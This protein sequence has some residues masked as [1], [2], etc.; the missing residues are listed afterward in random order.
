[1]ICCP[2]GLLTELIHVIL[3]RFQLLENRICMKLLLSNAAERL[4]H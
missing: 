2:D 3:A 4:R 1:M